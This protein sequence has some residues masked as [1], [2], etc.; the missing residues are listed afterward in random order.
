MACIVIYVI[1]VI[2]LIDNGYM[3]GY[4]DKRSYDRFREIN[5]WE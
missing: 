5:N 1:V 4:N 2:V 3:R